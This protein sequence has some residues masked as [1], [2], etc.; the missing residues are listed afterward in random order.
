MSF[1]SPWVLLGLLALPLL[2][3]W[4]VSEGQ[5]RAL[6]AKSFVTEPLIASVA[7]RRAGWRRHVPYVLLA[8]A[9]AVLIV[10]AARPQR[11]VAVPLKRGTVMLANDVS[12]SM[13]STDVK[14]SRLVA[15]Q[16]AALTFL[17]GIPKTVAVGSVQ[18][19]RHPTL[20][21]TPTHYHAL[22]RQAIRGLAPAGG[23]TA[24]GQAL[25]VA[26][27]TIARVPK[28]HD[29]KRPP[30]TIVLISDGASNVGIGPGQ[31]AR[32]ARRQKVPIYTIAIGTPGG[33]MTRKLHGRSVTTAV[34]V[35]PSQLRR[36]AAN[37]GGRS[38]SAADAGQVK[39]IYSH[40]ARSI[41]HTQ[42][43]QEL[44]AEVVIA[45]LVLLL[46]GSL[47]SMRWFVRIA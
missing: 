3:A 46:L 18:F 40:L 5:R 2:A 32:L 39:Q 27:Q 6:A 44:I 31:V 7:P 24:M 12:N 9:L 29:G 8:V 35:K 15:A 19:A 26:L 21:Q 45:G 41:G 43:H 30:G 28:A 4:Y 36:I 37:S 42:G 22:A 34:P 47:L 20:L 33:T 16:A 25:E 10:A 17:R 14:P 11:S 38:F 1:A 23:G 13:T